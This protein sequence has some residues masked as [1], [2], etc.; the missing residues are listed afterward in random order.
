ML[1]RGRFRWC[2]PEAN[3]GSWGLLAVEGP[4]RIGGHLLDVATWMWGYLDTLQ[5]RLALSGV[6][7]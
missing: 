6:G 5:T 2:L 7:H 4:D 1:V 3:D